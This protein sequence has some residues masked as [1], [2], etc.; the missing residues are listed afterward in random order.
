MKDILT[1]FHNGEQ[2]SSRPRTIDL[3]RVNII[4]FDRERKTARTH[5]AFLRVL[6]VIS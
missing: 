4:S 1:G 3:L 5:G 2:Y 6:P